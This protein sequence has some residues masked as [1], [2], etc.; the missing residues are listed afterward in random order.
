MDTFEACQYLQRS[1]GTGSS[2]AT[3]LIA[4]LSGLVSVPDVLTGLEKA[5][6]VLATAASERDCVRTA[7]L[8]EISK[9]ALVSMFDVSGIA[10]DIHVFLFHHYWID[11]VVRMGLGDN[12]LAARVLHLGKISSIASSSPCSSIHINISLRFLDSLQMECCHASVKRE[13]A[14]SIGIHSPPLVQWAIR[15]SK[16]G[17]TDELLMGS[18]LERQ[19]PRMVRLMKKV[20]RRVLQ[21]S[22]SLDRASFRYTP[23]ILAHIHKRLLTMEGD[24]EEYTTRSL[25][26]MKQLRSKLEMFYAV[27]PAF[28]TSSGPL[29]VVHPHHPITLTKT[30]ASASSSRTDQ[31]MSLTATPS[32]SRHQVLLIGAHQGDEASSP[33]GTAE[34]AKTRKTRLTILNCKLRDILQAFLLAIVTEVVGLMILIQDRTG[35]SWWPIAAWV[36]DLVLAPV[37]PTHL[38]HPSFWLEGALDD[39]PPSDPMAAERGRFTRGGRSGHGTPDS[40]LKP[41]AVVPLNAAASAPSEP[42]SPQSSRLRSLMAAKAVTPMNFRRVSWSTASSSDSE[43]DL[44]PKRQLAAEI[45]KRKQLPKSP[46][47]KPHFSL[48]SN[49]PSSHP[50]IDPI[51]FIITESPVGNS[52]P[53]SRFVRQHPSS[54]L[55]Q[56]GSDKEN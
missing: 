37:Q 30:S 11:R 23:R 41:A 49:S 29:T 55:D 18:L 32:G 46:K 38:H 31:L 5:Q 19:I 36:F 4:L 44:D 43:G 16:P 17:R 40:I 50:N 53:T 2:S 8:V 25:Q 54:S 1:I 47:P 10:M 12:R 33:G 13:Q 51:Q 52:P 24:S 28:R 6:K 21:V 20:T 15:K 22:W 34:L 39:L 14:S 9:E 26:I 42:G 27:G 48:M 3:K 35:M 56:N 45:K 7:F